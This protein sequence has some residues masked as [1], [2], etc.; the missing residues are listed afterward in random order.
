MDDRYAG[1]DIDSLLNRSRDRSQGRKPYNFGNKT[2]LYEAPEFS[3]RLPGEETVMEGQSV[4]LDCKVRGFPVPSLRWFKDDEEIIDHPRIHAEGDGK[5][6][7]SLYIDR[8]N[9]GD[10]AAYRCRAENIEGACSCFFFL[11]VK[12]KRTKK[13]KRNARQSKK[14]KE[15]FFPA[16]VCYNC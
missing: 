15:C 5:G 1:I 3:R 6:G 11:S 13:R 9:K 16:N 8:I 7:Y 4:V 14:Q 10:E 12:V 2:A